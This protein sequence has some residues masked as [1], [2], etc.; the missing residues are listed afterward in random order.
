MNPATK[1]FIEFENPCP[2][3]ESTVKLSDI[4]WV[5]EQ[6]KDD[7]T[8]KVVIA[9]R[10]LAAGAPELS[11]QEIGELAAQHG[12]NLRVESPDSLR[13]AVDAIFTGARPLREHADCRESRNIRSGTAQTGPVC[14]VSWQQ[15][16]SECR[17]LRQKI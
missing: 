10:N 2:T 14:I 5:F 3:P 11:Y 9:Q 1:E 12:L 7:F 16:I 15:S 13:E 8:L 4:D 17:P 6:F